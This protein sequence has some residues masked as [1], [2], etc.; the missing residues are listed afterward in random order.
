[1]VRSA[2][3]R[4][5]TE[6]DAGELVRLEGLCFHSPWTG[7]HLE[8]EL[9]RSPKAFFVLGEP[10]ILAYACFLVVLGEAELLRIGTAPEARRQGLGKKLLD[11]GFDHLKTLGVSRVMLEVGAENHSARALYESFGFRL[12][13]RRNGYYR[14]G[15][16]ALLYGRGLA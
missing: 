2:E 11:Y 12:E 16:D 10:R 6:A 4:T 14:D 15:T 1:M 9:R 7:D 5:A 8:Q 3:P 13:G